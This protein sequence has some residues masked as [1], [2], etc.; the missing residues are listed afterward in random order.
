M[1]K[2]FDFSK[3]QGNAVKSHCK[4]PLPPSELATINMPAKPLLGMHPKETHM[5]KPSHVHQE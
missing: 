1:E 3:N 4:I 5:W 2:V